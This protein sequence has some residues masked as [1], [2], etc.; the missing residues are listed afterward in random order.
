LKDT[1]GFDSE[2][3]FNEKLHSLGGKFALLTIFTLVRNHS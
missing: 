3:P 1:T 2:S